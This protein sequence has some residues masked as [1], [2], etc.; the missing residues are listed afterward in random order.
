MVNVLALNFAMP[1]PDLNLYLCQ[2]S[3]LVL[4]GAA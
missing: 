4:C 1:W 3:F 2:P